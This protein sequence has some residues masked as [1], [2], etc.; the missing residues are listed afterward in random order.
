MT[1]HDPGCRDGP[2]TTVSK[3]DC[4]DQ[5]TLSCNMEELYNSRNVTLTSLIN[6]H[7]KFHFYSQF[8]I[9]KMK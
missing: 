8:K 3:T 1:R 9:K 4:R 2:D 7:L 5:G 6:F